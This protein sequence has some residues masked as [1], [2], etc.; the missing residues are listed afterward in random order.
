MLILYTKSYETLRYGYSIEVWDQP[1]LPLFS[2]TRCTSVYACITDIVSVRWCN[3]DALLRLF[4]AS[5]SV[6]NPVFSA[7][8]TSGANWADQRVV[9]VS[10]S[11]FRITSNSRADR[12]T[13][14]HA[15][16]M[17]LTP[18][19]TTDHTQSGQSSPTTDRPVHNQK[20][21]CAARSVARWYHN[22]IRLLRNWTQNSR[23]SW[24]W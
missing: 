1:K 15:G 14:V 7:S 21:I 9:I 2:E 5:R 18:A 3:T 20:P 8:E 24:L 13:I 4:T 12:P 6:S 19:M 17:T 10:E 22:R 16:T 11:A 23:P